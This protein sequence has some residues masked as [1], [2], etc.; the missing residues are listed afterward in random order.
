ML[1][2]IN[3]S[4]FRGSLAVES[5]FALLEWGSGG[6]CSHNGIISFRSSTNHFSITG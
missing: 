1:C 6:M 5:L 3:C 2:L 4:F